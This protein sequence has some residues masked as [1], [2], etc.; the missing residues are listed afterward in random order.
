VKDANG[1]FVKSRLDE[2]RLQTIAEATGGFYL[3]LQNGRPEMHRLATDG[4]GTMTEKDIDARMSRKAIERYQWPL[5]GGLVLLVASLFVGERKR[6]KADGVARVAAVLLLLLGIPHGALARNAGLEAYERGDYKA[7]R[8]QFAK[9]LERR[10]NSAELQFNLGSAAYQEKAYDKALE[11]FAKA[12][13]SSDP[14][15]RAAA[16]YNLANTLYQRGAVQKEK[17]PKLQEWKNALQHYEEALKTQPENADAQ[18]NR[19]LVRRLIAELEKEPPKS[20]E[21][22]KQEKDKK[23]QEKKDKEKQDQKDQQK[24][25]Q[26]DEK[27]E[28]KDKK[29]GEKGDEKDESGKGD[30]QDPEKKDGKDG[31]LKDEQGKEGD[32]SEKSEPKDQKEGGPD[33]EPK[34]GEGKPEPMPGQDEKKKEGELKSA[35]QGEMSPQEAKEAEQAAEAA[36]SRRRQDD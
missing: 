28:S 15:L 20:E 8:E 18:H 31:E 36:C 21:E 2:S 5:A 14:K 23:D 9:Q 24:D 13:T 4:L 30:D 6:A 11:A 1:N 35:P 22:K 34:D 10:P 16:E 12:V 19:D 29:D 27:S 26:G 17:A 32:Q 3:H 7:A 25:Q 33:Q